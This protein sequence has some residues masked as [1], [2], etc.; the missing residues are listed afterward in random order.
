M[1]VYVLH[2]DEWPGILINRVKYS[3]ATC[4]KITLHFIRS[5]R[6]ENQAKRKTETRATLT[7]L[8]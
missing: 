4:S 5:T 2:V 8:Q 6:A 7:D 1:F 3:S